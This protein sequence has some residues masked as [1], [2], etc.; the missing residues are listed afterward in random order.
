MPFLQIVE[1]FFELEHTLESTLAAVQQPNTSAQVRAWLVTTQ[2]WQV[3]LAYLR[4]FLLLVK[5]LRPLMSCFSRMRGNW[6]ALPGRCFSAALQAGSVGAGSC[7]GG[8]IEERPW[9]CI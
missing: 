6:L 7:T 4:D 1:A 2:S 5:D 3:A 9:V 8:S